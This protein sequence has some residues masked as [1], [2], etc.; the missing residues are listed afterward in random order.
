MT[1]TRRGLIACLSTVLL[2]ACATP[3]VAPL[4]VNVASVQRI[5]GGSMELR[6]LARL[7][8]QNVNDSAIEFSGAT[9]ELKLYGKVIGTGVSDG[10]GLVPAFGE[11]FVEIPITVSAIGDVRQAIGLYGAPDRKLDTVLTGRLA[12]SRFDNLSFEWRGEL[13]MPLPRGS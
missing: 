12:G 1:L 13:A 4:R 10:R 6:F 11:T 2:A 7:R 3:T 5:E 9:A 8:V